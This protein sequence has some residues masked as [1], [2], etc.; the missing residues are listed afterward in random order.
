MYSLAARAGDADSS[1]FLTTTVYNGSFMPLSGSHIVNTRTGRGSTTD[2]FGMFRM[3][4]Y[5]GDTLM[6]SHLAYQDTLVTVMDL[7]EKAYLVLERKSYSLP[8]AKIFEWGSTY[9]DFR[10]AIIHMPNQQTLG[11]SLRWPRADP[12]HIPAEMD[13]EKIKSTGFLLTSP[14]SYFYHNYNR[15]ARNARKLFWRGKNREAVEAFEALISPEN[16]SEVTGYT[17]EDLL[18]FMA[19]FLTVSVTLYYF[20]QI[21]FH[22]QHNL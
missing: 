17:G 12:N 19:F 13:E 18:E 22:L 6:I 10:E 16:L 21:L 5:S 20:L 15:K 9:G 7:M 1:L 3:R 4:V 14:V 11:E 8:E 2:R